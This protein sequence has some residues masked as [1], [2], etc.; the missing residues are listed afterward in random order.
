MS[1]LVALHLEDAVLA[2]VEDG[3]V[4]GA[5]AQVEDGDL[6]VLLLVERVRQRRRGRLVDDAHPLLDVLAGPG[7][8]IS[9][10]VSKPAIAAASMV[11]CRWASLKYAGTVMTALR[12]V[13]PEVGLGGFLELAQ[14]HRRDF[15]RRELLAVDVHL[16]Q[17]VRPA[18]D[19]V[20]ERVSLRARPRCAGGP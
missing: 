18:D 20:R 4:E 8:S 14:D 16:H 11:A 6:L 2:D 5:A 1:P 7:S 9:H 13:W 15:R 12:T 17:F 3:D 19:L 10:S